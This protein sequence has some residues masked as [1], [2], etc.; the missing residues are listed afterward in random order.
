MKVVLGID[1]A[2][3]NHNPSGVALVV[4]RTGAA[5]ECLAVAPSYQ[6][7]MSLAGY[8]GAAPVIPALL[9]A[10]E[11]LLKRHNTPK[12]KP[13]IIAVDMP[14]WNQAGLIQ[15]RRPSDNSISLA[16]G[17]RGT[18]ALP[19]T[20][21][22][23]GALSENFSNEFAKCGY[24]LAVAQNTP[25]ARGHHLVEVY[26][27]PALLALLNSP[28]RV[29]Y[30]MHKTKSYWAGF[31]IPER[32]SKLLDVYRSINT[33]LC[34]VL[35]DTGL[36]IPDNVATLSALKPYEDAL[37]ALICAWVGI[38]CLE[39]KA[40]A[41]GDHQSA[42]WVPDK[43]EHLVCELARVPSF[44]TFEDRLHPLV[45][46]YISSLLTSNNE[47]V[48][49]SVTRI[50][51]NN[52]IIEW[53][54]N[55]QELQPIA[56]TAH[57]DKIN[58]FGA[59]DINELP[60]AIDG[61]EIVGQLDDAVGVA[62]C[63]HI[64]SECLQIKGCPPIMLLL[65]EMEERGSYRN[66][67]LLK[68]NGQGI[69]L[70]PGAHRIAD[71]LLKENKLPGAVITFDT[72]AVFG[73]TGGIAVHSDFWEMEGSCDVDQSDQLISR[74]QKLVE[75]IR[76]INPSVQLANGLNDYVTYGT[77]L[78]EL[79]GNDIPSI[80][81]E[82]AIDPIHAIGE[83]MKIADIQSVADT[84]IRLIK[85]RV[86]ANPAPAKPYD[87][88]DKAGNPGDVIK[89]VALLAAADAIMKNSRDVFRFADTF[90]GYAFNPIRSSGEWQEGI[91]IFE[92]LPK[93]PTNEAITF[94]HSLW[95][96]AYGLAGSTYPGSSTF[97]RKLCMK[98]GVQ[99]QL[100]LWDTSPA[101]ISQLKQTYSDN[102]AR[103]FDRPATV[104]DFDAEKPDLLLID[105]PDLSLIASL[106]AFVELSDAVVIWLP[107]LYTNGTET[108]A[109]KNAYDYCQK[110][111]L[112]V[113]TVTWKSTRSMCGCRL[114]HK[115]PEDAAGAIEAAVGDIAHASGWKV[116]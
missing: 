1:A 62:L 42:I 31:Q 3:T 86:R 99:A 113:T 14:L 94:W 74:T 34:N 52:L 69:E 12:Q 24:T 104:K 50:P 44:T 8:A 30:K 89:H 27:H 82:P 37:D 107:V 20:V 32:I 7:Y 47:P 11:T 115:L 97:I 110:Q 45:Q 26:P 16:F 51:E 60:V 66:T 22:R 18:A 29:P 95:S 93:E 79:K 21:E 72:S 105:P 17:G 73:K 2:W 43:L 33:A 5:W 71:Y 80:A 64:L 61:D 53:K 65:S 41:Y 10:T 46:Q 88:H 91:G 116:S 87:H 100:S 98:R 15:G 103:I 49:V 39:G 76:A 78:N 9:Q 38:C 96:C 59:F 102:E 23:P 77:C 55:N 68:N 28:Y 63:L 48:N 70:S 101:V 40:K 75:E 81:I 90:A 13:D 6:E 112:R 84:V 35:G 111:G 54:G 36:Q 108:A 92:K 85:R 4:Q 83:R 109:S 25:F 58:H 19:P 106:L 56:L 67:S 57:L 114:A